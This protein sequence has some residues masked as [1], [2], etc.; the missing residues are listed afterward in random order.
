MY[1][2]EWVR[3]HLPEEPPKGLV[4]WAANT[5]PQDLNEDITIITGERI[6]ERVSMM[7]L[8]ENVTVGKKVWAERCECTV[9]GDYYYAAKVPGKDAFYCVVGDDGAAYPME[10]G[11]DPEESTRFGLPVMDVAEHDQIEC[12]LCNCQTMVYSSKR[13]KGGRRKQIQVAS[14]HRVGKY[15]VILYWLVYNQIDENGAYLGAEPRYAFCIGERGG[16]T[17]YSHR[18]PGFAGNDCRAGFWRILSDNSDRWD[19]P[20]HDWESINNRKAGTMTF[21]EI[22]DMEGTTAEKTGLSAYWKESGYR[23]VDYIK[24]W[25]HFPNVE[26]ICNSGFSCLVEEALACAYPETAICEALDMHKKKPH[27][28]F[29]MSR[30][31]FKAFRKRKRKTDLD[32]M[33]RWGKYK[34]LGG[35]CIAEDFFPRIKDYRYTGMEAAFSLMDTY[36]GT[37]LP[38]LE[39]YMEKQRLRPYDLGMLRDYRQFTRELYPRHQL[40]SEEL[41]PRNLQEAHAR[42]AGIRVRQIDAKKAAEFQAGFDRVYETY[43]DLQWT[44]GELCMVLPRN[45][46]DLIRE[47]EILRHCVG[48]YGPQHSS[49]RAII[50]FVRHYRRPERCYYTLN[51]GFTGQTPN[52]IQLHGYGNERHGEHKQYAHRIPRKVRD[53]VDRWEKEVLATWWANQ[54]KEKSA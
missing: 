37:D 19:T 18:D 45:N 12:P 29:K 2:A 27:E 31:E 43:K 48:G 38:Q 34:A 17:A 44:D 26:N 10:P 11:E 24:M 13:L 8:M 49:G 20:Y 30:P 46:G 47:G 21:P 6:D 32:D 33:K 52:E 25:R 35:G 7:E 23:P 9:C 40:T 1:D 41:W 50:I 16:I 4:R 42:V 28:I 22:P 3:Q 54:I 39:R 53:F 15:G 5:S 36:P 51:I 14:L